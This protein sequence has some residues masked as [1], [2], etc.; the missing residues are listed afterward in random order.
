MQ[1]MPLKNHL[2][3]IELKISA[4]VLVW[5]QSKSNNNVDDDDGG[6]DDVDHPYIILDYVIST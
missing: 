3:F 5:A 1:K 6:D 4:P 2:T